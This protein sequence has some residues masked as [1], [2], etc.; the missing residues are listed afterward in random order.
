MPIVAGRQNLYQLAIYGA[1][2]VIAVIGAVVL[3]YHGTLNSDAV[4]AILTG[5]LALAGANAGSAGAVYNAVN[6]KSLSTPQQI[7]ESGATN[8][9]AIVAAAASGARDVK[10]VDP[11]P[12]DV[13]A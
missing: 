10:P 4:A 8:R 12:H 3:G 11:Q 9:T 5:A 7:A 6:G 2:A 13:P 1:I